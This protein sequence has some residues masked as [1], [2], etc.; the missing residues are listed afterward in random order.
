[1]ND[2]AAL[3]PFTYVGQPVEIIYR[4]VLLRPLE[5]GKIFL[6]VHKD[7]YNRTGNPLQ[8]IKSL[9]DSEHVADKVDWK[10]IT[11]I[12]QLKEGLARDVTVGSGAPGRPAGS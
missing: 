12:T 6:E 3:F 4:P 5:D 9:V 7:I 11:L 1:M 2:A 8:E 10:R